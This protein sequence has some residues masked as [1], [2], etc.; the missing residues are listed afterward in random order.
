[1]GGI[2]NIIPVI[3]WKHTHTNKTATHMIC[4]PI[5]DFPASKE[6]VQLGIGVRLTTAVTLIRLR[7]S[8]PPEQQS[9]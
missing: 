3:I 1:M 4:P 6:V 2:L 5:V 7:L 9:S 8:F